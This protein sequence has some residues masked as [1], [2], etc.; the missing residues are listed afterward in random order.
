ME[1]IDRLKIL[2]CEMDL[3]PDDGGPSSMISASVKR[4]K[5]LGNKFSESIHIT[6]TITPGG[7]QIK[8]LKT[9]LTSACENNCFY[10]PFRAGR[11][12]RRSTLRPDEMAN[13]FMALCSAGIAE[14]LFLSSGVVD[15]GVHTQDKIIESAEILRNIHGYRGYIHL[16]LMPGVEKDQVEQAMK[17]ANRVS[18]NLEAPDTI[19]LGM[20]APRK[21]FFDELLQPLQ[22]VDEIRK[23]KPSHLGWNRHWPSTTTQFVVGV[24][25]E[26]DRDLLVT[27]EYLNKHLSLARA[28]YSAFRPIKDTPFENREP[29]SPCREHRLY[30]ASFLLRDYEFEVDELPFNSYGSLPDS[31]DPKTAWARLHLRECPLEINL[32]TRSELIRIPGIGPK[33]A[34]SILIARR[35]RRLRQMDDLRRIGVDP[36]SSAPYILL[37]GKRPAQQLSF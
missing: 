6:S 8:L 16:K 23:T 15:G 9:L 11:D 34:Q 5:S 25:G 4:P 2:S 33:G 37:D 30:Q 24:V 31:V 3:E 36:S 19:H 17:L 20:L 28:Y 29:G 27:T 35:N 18:I 32:A 13:V 12:F 7:K 1:P 10:C 14:G 22:W 21:T 26:S